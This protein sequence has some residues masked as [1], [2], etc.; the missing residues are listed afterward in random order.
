MRVAILD[1]SGFTLPYDHCLCSALAEQGHEVVFVAN[2]LPEGPWA[3][4]TSY[5][6]WQHFYRLAARSWWNPARKYI[7]AFEH[8][9]EMASLIPR[10]RRWKPDVIHFQWLPLPSVDRLFLPRLRKLGP[11]VLTVHDTEPYHG[12]P[13][14]RFQL[15]GLQSALR[16]FDRYIVHTDYSRRQLVK[17]LNL[18]EGKVSVVPHGVFAHYRDLIECGNAPAIGHRME[19]R[20]K[21]VLFF[22]ILKPYKGVDL[23]LQAFSLLPDSVRNGSLLRVIGYP[24]MAV[25][26]LRDLARRLAIDDRIEWD[27]RFVDEREVAL[28]FADADVVV[29]PYRRIDQSGVLMIALA[30]GKPVVATRVGGFP[31]VIS[32]GVH[33]YVVE[34]GDANSLARALTSVLQDNELRDRMEKAVRELAASE[35]SWNSIAGR[36]LGIYQSLLAGRRDG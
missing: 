9:L 19:G 7:K 33:G 6:Q 15:F 17:S 26:P 30:F 18:P 25:E 23:L 16:A 8:P 2:P 27:L 22:G 20:K 35:L 24:R 12:A 4:T 10:L 5:T 32:D 28:H 31:E 11:L 13:T 21:V 3:K 29:L 14:S 34:P 36:T 1:P